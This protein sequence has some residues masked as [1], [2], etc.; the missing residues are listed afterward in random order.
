LSDTVKEEHG[1]TGGG[2]RYLS[3]EPTEDMYCQE[4]PYSCLAA[5]ARRLLLEAGV[6]LSEAAIVAKTGYIE[7]WGTT[8]SLVAHALD[9][10]HPRLGFGGGAVD[11][12]AVLVLGQL[13]PW[14]ASLRGDRGALH[15]VIVDKIEG[16]VVHVRDPW[17]LSGPGSG[18]GTRATIRLADFLE[19]WH[20][21]A[22]NVIS[23]NRLK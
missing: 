1:G 12:R 16:G 22:N 13:S 5:C 4:L 21:A 10:L 15:G 11:P 7:G 18:T 9:E 14:I 19:H 23:A 17:G 8:C 6:E 20:Y 2:L 3:E